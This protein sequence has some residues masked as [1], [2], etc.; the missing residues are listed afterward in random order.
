MSL[1]NPDDHHF[2]SDWGVVEINALVDTK[3]GLEAALAIALMEHASATHYAIRINADGSNAIEFM[4]A[5]ANFVA[6]WAEA[7][8]IYGERPDTDGSTQA[9]FRV[10][11]NDDGWAYTLALVSPE[12]VIYGK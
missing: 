1:F 9:G 5:L 10:Q 8:A 2:K 6:L 7:N 12:W 4:W 11:T 3:R